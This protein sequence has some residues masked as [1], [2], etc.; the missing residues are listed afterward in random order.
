[1][2]LKKIFKD[3][4][5]FLK[6]FIDLENLSEEDKVKFIKEYILSIHRELG[7]ILDTI[8]WKLHR[9]NEIVKSETNTAE[10]II[11]CFKFLLNLCLILKID[12]EKFVNEFDRKSMVVWQRY[13]QE[14]LKIISKEDKVCAIDLDDTLSNS[15]EYFTK[16]YNEMNF[17]GELFKNRSQIKTE[18]PVLE[19][20]KFKSWFRESG[21]KLNIPVKSGAKEL[22]DFLKEKGYK[23]VVISARPYEKYNRIFSDTLQW[24]NKNQIQYD[25]VYF[26]RDK[27]IKILKELPHLSFI[28]EDDLDYAQQISKLGYK[29]YLL[30]DSKIENKVENENIIIIN[31]LTEIKKHE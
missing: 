14:I 12:D 16:I 22:C 3:Q 30:Y 6:N 2:R 1:M 17:P 24:L 29:V 9:K 7:E 11:D 8:P 10:E 25:A 21:E 5:D 28:I 4:K 26:E 15:D 20:E 23:I 31:D 27:H 13:N 18:L 19:Y